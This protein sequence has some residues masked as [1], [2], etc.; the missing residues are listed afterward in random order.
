MFQGR[1]D[2]PQGFSNLVA[3]SPGYDMENVRMTHFWEK[4]LK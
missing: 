4:S 2:K 3:L 1:Q